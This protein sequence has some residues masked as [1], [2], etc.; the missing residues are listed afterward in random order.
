MVM[1]VPFLHHERIG[2][3]GVVAVLSSVGGWLWL[4][5]LEVGVLAFRLGFDQ[6]VP[7]RFPARSRKTTVQPVLLSGGIHV[8]P[9]TRKSVRRA[10]RASSAI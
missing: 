6:V 5:F 4:W 7:W 2:G 10:V 9:L 3:G 8:H 1:S